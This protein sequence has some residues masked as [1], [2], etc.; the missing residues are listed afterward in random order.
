MSAMLWEF[1]AYTVIV[2]WGVLIVAFLLLHP[3]E[4]VTE[5]RR[6][7]D[8]WIG[9][10]LQ[11]LAYALVWV[12]ARPFG[13]QIGQRPLPL[14]LEFALVTSAVVIAL[15]SAW[16]VIEAVRALGK[17]FAVA[18][19]VISGHQLVTSGP[20]RVVRH[21]IYTGMLGMLLATAL[22]FSS[23]PGLILSVATY[24]AGTSMRI[25]K[26]E[27][28]LRETFGKDFEDYAD[29]VPALVPGLF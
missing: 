26:E 6:A 29:E 25:R 14:A 23:W 8:W 16:L 10:L 22:A 21:P 9:L 11:G 17:Q 7:Q 18:A 27:R 24:L 20:F 12:F 13:S 19:R 5:V 15:L 2:I 4:L 3:R 28:L 1:L